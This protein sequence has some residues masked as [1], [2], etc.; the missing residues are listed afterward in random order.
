MNKKENIKDW[1][2]TFEIYNRKKQVFE[3]I[4][5]V[6]SW[7]CNEKKNNTQFRK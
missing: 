2:P 5:Y 7:F 1:N 4:S 3:T 6:K